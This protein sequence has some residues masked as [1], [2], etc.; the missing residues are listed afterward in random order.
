MTPSAPLHRSVLVL[1]LSGDRIQVLTRIREPEAIERLR[2]RAASAP[3]TFTEQLARLGL[4]RAPN[5][6]EE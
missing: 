4:R 3:L 1:G 5:D 6:R 2:N